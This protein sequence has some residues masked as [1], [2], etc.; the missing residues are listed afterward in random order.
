[1]EETDENDDVV[2]SLVQAVHINLNN[3]FDASVMPA[4]KEQLKE[5]YWN[6]VFVSSD[7]PTSDEWFDRIYH[8][9]NEP[10]RHYHTAVHLKEIF[11]YVTILREGG[12]VSKNQFAVIVWATFFHDLVYDPKSNKN[13][14]ESAVRWLDFC[15]VMS[16]DDVTAKM[17]ETIILATEKH[18][19]I[20]MPDNQDMEQAQALFLDMDMAVL[21]KSKDSYMAYA[22]LIRRE[23]SFVE[24]DVYCSK[25]SEILRKFTET[26][27]YKTS[28]FQRAMEERARANL[29]AEIELL[30]QGTIPSGIATK[31]ESNEQ[32]SDALVFTEVT[33]DDN[34]NISL[35]QQLR[36][37][38]FVEEQ[39]I[40]QEVEIDGK[41]ECPETT[42]ILVQSSLDSTT[43]VGTG[44]I[45]VPKSKD[46]KSPRTASLGRIAI[47]RPWRRKGLG[48]QI[49]KRLEDIARRKSV[50]RLHL[51]PH[52]YL[53]KFYQNLGFTRASDW[54]SVVNDGCQLIRME[55]ILGDSASFGEA[56]SNGS[57]RGPKRICLFGTSAN[58]PTGSGGHVGVVQGLLDLTKEDNYT[59]LFDEVHVLPVYYHTFAN[60]RQLLAPYGHRVAMCELAFAGLS[61][62]NRVVI[63]RAEER[64]F[65]RHL[66]RI[67]EEKDLASLQVGT[68]DLLEMLL[69]EANE[70]NAEVEF[71]FCLGADTFLDLT[72][73]KWKRSK[74]VLRLLEGRL[75]VVHREG[76]AKK[77]E[78][79]ARIKHV[80]DTE[81]GR[82]MMMDVPVLEDVS[83]SKARELTAKHDLQKLVP[84]KVVDYI[85][86]HK[87]YSFGE[88]I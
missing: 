66:G 51:T 25:R 9:H 5:D 18:Q 82:V 20:P 80:N 13:E 43:V 17:V 12:V 62:K 60:K 56:L 47:S 70:S 50:Y 31:Q 84:P 55:K 79:L 81:G 7:R 58:P 52:H 10:G 53:E 23:Y 57:K 38:V 54:E 48:T 26:T 85:Q 75:V 49:M 46:E 19:L 86:L 35:C 65:H 88:G 21:G 78:L 8:Q 22:A 27:I 39:G 42:H 63:S 1:M 61:S 29:H 24:H 41:D 14:K 44:R 3:N 32:N 34:L 6:A 59:L 76:M 15:E 16:I 64:S 28:V 74:D 72:A 71:S 83:S 67:S 69:E 30:E 73:W 11:D 68:A 40:P 2:S 45:I 77:E 87:L 36:L 4:L 37:C 33:S